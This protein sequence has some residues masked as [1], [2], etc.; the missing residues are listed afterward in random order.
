MAEPRCLVKASNH[1]FVSGCLRGPIKWLRRSVRLFRCRPAKQQLTELRASG[2]GP[3]TSHAGP[4]PNLYRR[5][6]FLSQKSSPATFDFFAELPLASATATFVGPLPPRPSEKG[7]PT[8][9]TNAPAAGAYSTQPFGQD[10]RLNANTVCSG[11]SCAW[12]GSIVTLRTT[13]ES[14]LAIRMRKPRLTA[15]DNGSGQA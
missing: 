3:A 9:T 7:S 15:A 12:A 4:P 5:F 11:R 13:N 10:F 1:R 8:P 14:A 6:L 2:R